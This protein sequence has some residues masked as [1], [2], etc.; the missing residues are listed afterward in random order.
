MKLFLE[1]TLKSI[2]VAQM[3][4][5]LSGSFLAG[6]LF[7]GLHHRVGLPGHVGF[8]LHQFQFPSTP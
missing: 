2:S 7:G 6:Q 3:P 8:D 5:A 1:P 4:V